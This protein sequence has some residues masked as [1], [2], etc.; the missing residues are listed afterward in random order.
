MVKKLKKIAD[1]KQDNQLAKAVRDSAQQ[2][3]L[4]GLGAFAKAREERTKVFEALVSEGRNIQSRTRAL[5]GE[6]LGEMAGKV[7]EVRDRVEKQATDSWDKLEQV[8]ESRVSRALGRLGVPTSD[9]I[10]ALIERVDSLTASVEALGGKVERK[11]GTSAVKPA[12]KATARRTASAKPAVADKPAPSA[13]PAKAAADTKAAKGTKARKPVARTAAAKAAK[14]AKPRK[15]A[16][17]VAPTARPATKRARA[18]ASAQPAA[19][20]P[21]DGDAQA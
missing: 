20:V 18:T 1:S 11:R 3:W 10:Q 9:E 5:A 15:A 12:R 6:R 8:F 16:S 2:I 13:R 7:G 19:S 17:V 4:A 21:A 14:A